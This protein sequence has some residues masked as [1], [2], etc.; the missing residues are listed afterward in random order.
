MLKQLES[1]DA[2]QINIGAE[3]SVLDENK[4]D[5]DDSFEGILEIFKGG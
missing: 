1:H 2:S 5:S 4:C 3:S